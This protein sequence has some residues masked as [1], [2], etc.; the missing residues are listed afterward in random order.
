[1]WQPP[2]NGSLW[3][4]DVARLERLGAEL[5]EHAAHGLADRAEVG[6]VEP[7]LRDHPAARGRTARTRSRATR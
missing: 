3:I 7:A 2:R 5:V 1:M 4:D 6:R